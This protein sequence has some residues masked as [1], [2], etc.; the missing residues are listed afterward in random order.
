MKF[1]SSTRNQ[2]I[3]ALALI[4]GFY[5]FAA[6]LGSAADT[7]AYVSDFG[8]VLR[9]LAAT[10]QVQTMLGAIAIDALLG[11]IA[12]LRVNLFDTAK[13]GNYLRTNVLPYVFGY[14]LIALMTYPVITAIVYASIMASVVGSIIDNL[15]RAGAGT[16]PPHDAISNDLPPAEPHA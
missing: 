5:A 8:G 15:A 6:I 13:V 10:W 12:A 9:Q 2:G 1:L 3:L 14:V 11:M 16:T 4:V 7:H